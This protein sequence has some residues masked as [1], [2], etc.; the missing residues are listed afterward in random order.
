M[1]AFD[2]LGAL[3]TLMAYKVD[4]VVIGGLAARL[5]GSPTVT[6]DL[7]ICHDR[8]ATNLKRVAGALEEMEARLRLPDPAERV[9]ISIDERLL[10]ATQDLTLMTAFGGFDLLA[11]PAG[12]EGYKELIRG[13]V[14]L[15]LDRG[16]SV[17]VASIDDLIR[18]KR[19]SGRPK[20]L[21]EV[22]VLTALQDEMGHESE[23]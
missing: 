8:S 22:E 16:L 5:H 15:E 19:A 14:A 20:D 9:D 1:R 18:M 11:R 13:A 6:N 3:R 10:A 12:T 23:R 4:F 7:D 2:P 21:I 17:A